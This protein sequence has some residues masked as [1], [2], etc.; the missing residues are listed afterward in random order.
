VRQGLVD[1]EAAPVRMTTLGPCTR[2]GTAVVVEIRAEADACE[3]S[4]RRRVLRAQATRLE[5][6]MRKTRELVQALRPAEGS[7]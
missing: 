4:K 5:T 6:D 1:A 7:A 3:D 2:M